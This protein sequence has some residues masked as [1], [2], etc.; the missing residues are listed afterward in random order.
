MQIVIKLNRKPH[1]SAMER[2]IRAGRESDISFWGRLSASLDKSIPGAL[3]QD[4]EAIEMM[5]SAINDYH[6]D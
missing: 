1:L 2:D 6:G 5:I 3:A 4:I